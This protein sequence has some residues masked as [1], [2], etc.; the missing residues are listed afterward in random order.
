MSAVLVLAGLALLVLPGAFASTGRHLRPR[1]WGRLNL[2]AMRLGLWAIQFG[3]FLVAAPTV[4]HAACVHSVA[5]ACHRV[6]GPVMPG[7]AVTGWASAAA[8]VGLFG[9][10]R[11]VRQRA[12]R[13]QRAGRVDSWLGE[14]QHRAEAT[15]VLLPTNDL[16]A[17]AALGSPHQVVLSR[18]LADSLTPD[19][20]DAVVGHELVHLRHRHDRYLVAAAVID[21]TLGWIPALR[22]ST[23]ALRLSVERWADEEA[24]QRPGSRDSIR[25]AL[26]K[27]SE[28]ML[29]LLPAFTAACTLAARLDALGTP[30]PD[31]TL[32]QRAAVAGPVFALASVVAAC[33]VLWS[34]YT[35]HGVLGLLGFCSV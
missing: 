33:L 26:A 20:L 22:R 32:R 18:G 11:V 1:E 4:L 14:H 31:P 16:V 3:L 25:R 5:D 13:L 2:A 8:T 10:A 35:H 27:T 12:I 9:A 23:A 29:S 34:T 6:L 30:P 24:A 15:L 17:Y 19:E 21:A 7:G 28:T